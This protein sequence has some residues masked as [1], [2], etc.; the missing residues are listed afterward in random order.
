MGGAAQVREGLR[1]TP[2]A[3][4][5]E[6]TAMSIG[7]GG[8]SDPMLQRALCAYRRDTAAA[9][10]LSARKIELLRHYEVT[11]M[12]EALAICFWGRSGS[13]LLASYLDGHPDVVSL[14]MIAGEAIYPFFREFAGLSIWE[15]LIAY[16]TFS[17]ERSGIEA[18]IFE[19]EYGLSAADYYAAVHALFALYG[20]FPSA[21]LDARPRFF[22]FLH[23]AYG[24]AQGRPAGRRRPLMVYAQHWPN[25][26]LARQFIEDFPTAR[27]I[28]TVRD[29]ISSFDSWFERVLDMQ[30]H[31]AGRCW[32]QAPQY[33]SAAVETARHLF[34]WDRAHAGME[35]RSRA[36]RFEDLH[37]EP[38]AAMRRL[39]QWLKIPYHPCLLDSTWNGAPYVL[40]IRGV[41]C[42]G[43][44]PA[45]ALRR[46]KNLSHFDRMLIFA[47]LHDDMIEWNYPLPP[48]VRRGW[49]R[50]C[51]VAAALLVPL[52]MEWANTR[53]VLFQQALPNL[54]R[55]RR[56]FALGAPLFLLHRR[57]R[58][59]LLIV[60]AARTRLAGK[61]AILKPV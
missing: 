32:E 9:E 30:Y 26:E 38:E 29:P 54:R 7:F 45:N 46:S 60:S 55:G 13:Y 22:Q 5:P 6:A 49:V 59:I 51:M 21:W 25:E 33:V 47:L 18:G 56:L 36:F 34:G 19:G 8:G 24:A 2:S 61:R 48:A 57:L 53:I 41:P 40:E 28:H 50:W 39:A 42:C 43:A 10:A 12:Q 44:N 20:G 37:V 11:E 27:F 31:G 4:R 17:F 16:P 52:K 14:P 23:A 15:K 1:A 35:E 58:M 3:H